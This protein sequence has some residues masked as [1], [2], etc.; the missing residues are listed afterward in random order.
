MQIKLVEIMIQVV[1]LSPKSNDDQKKRSSP[2]KEGFLT[3]KLDA[4]QKKKKKVFTAIWLYIQPELVG[5][6]CAN[7]YFFV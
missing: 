6:I 7:S 2:K 3:P 4:D 1:L 5:F